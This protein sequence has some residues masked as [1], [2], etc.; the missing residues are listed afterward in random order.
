M[1]RKYIQNTIKSEFN[2]NVLTLVSG[3][4]IAQLITLLC[5]LV[6]S[7]LY[8][9]GDFGIFTLFISISSVISLVLAGRYELAI[10]LPKTDREGINVLGF[11]FKINLI[12]TSIL[13]VISIVLYFVFDYIFK[14]NILLKRWLIFIPFIASF[15]N[16]SNIFQNW[17]IRKKDFR[18][19]SY[20]KIIN[21]FVNNGIAIALGFLVFGAWGIFIGN[22]FGLIALVLFFGILFYNKYKQDLSQIDKVD[23]KELSSR[24]IDLPKANSFQSVIDAFQT[25]GITYLM[26]I[27]FSSTTIGLYAMTL[28]ILQAPISLIISSITQVFYQKA[29]EQYCHGIDIRP[30]IKKTVLKTLYIALPLIVVAMI[31]SPVVFAVVFGER[32]REA[33]VYARILAPWIFLDFIRIPISQVPIIVNKQKTQLF[34][35]LFNNLIVIL[36]MLYAGLVIHNIRT[37]LILISLFQVF[38]I[39]GIVLWIYRIAKINTNI[40]K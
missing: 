7:R 16:L 14:E 21:S 9:P 12:N 23:M 34:Y 39:I 22:L 25:Q 11:S 38:Y 40:F 3:T 1:L 5:S 20:G 36:A 6:L 27:F 4:T 30:I 2:R 26:A 29:S 35:S 10:N 8:S 18:V 15:L 13:F 33:G 24:Y 32:W 31:F 28:R 19:I 37:G 17:F